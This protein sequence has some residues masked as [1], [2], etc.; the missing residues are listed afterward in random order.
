MRHPWK[1]SAKFAMKS[2]KQSV[3]R[4]NDHIHTVHHLYKVSHGYN[5][6]FGPRRCVIHILLDLFRP[7]R[8]MLLV[9]RAGTSFR[10]LCWALNMR[11]YQENRLLLLYHLIL[12]ASHL[13]SM[14]FRMKLWDFV[15]IEYEYLVL[16]NVNPLFG[17]HFTFDVSYVRTIK[18]NANNFYIRISL[19]NVVTFA[20]IVK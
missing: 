12:F 6:L 15:F 13:F 18:V 7:C 5:L 16:K 14:Y 4:E 8:I 19:S 3:R 9:T 1:A 11:T 20:S 17:L 10:D 2:W